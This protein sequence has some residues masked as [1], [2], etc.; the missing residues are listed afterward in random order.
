[1]G[2]LQNFSDIVELNVFVL[3]HALLLM[4]KKSALRENSLD[5]GAMVSRAHF[6]LT[7]SIGRNVSYGRVLF[8]PWANAK[9]VHGD[10]HRLPHRGKGLSGCLRAPHHLPDAA[11]I[12]RSCI[13]NF[14]SHCRCRLAGD[15]RLQLHAQVRYRGA[16]CVLSREAGG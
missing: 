8:R 3:V 6:W 16:W 9:F 7:S 14:Y 1:M 5:F 10:R 11:A 13:G 4:W 15:L 12:A 2:L